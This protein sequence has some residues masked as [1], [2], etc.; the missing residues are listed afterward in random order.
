MRVAAGVVVPAEGI[1]NAAS[2]MTAFVG[3]AAMVGAASWPA[4]VPSGVVGSN[5]LSR[6]WP[7]VPTDVVSP[8]EMQP[9]SRQARHHQGLF[10]GLRALIQTLGVGECHDGCTQHFSWLPSVFAIRHDGV[11]VSADKLR[12]GKQ[13]NRIRST[14]HDI[15]TRIAADVAKA[16]A[17]LRP[18]H[19]KRKAVG[20]F[21]T[22][23]DL[24]SEKQLRREL[25]KLLPEA[26]F[27]GEESEATGLHNDWLWVVDPIDGTSNFSRGL[28]HFAVS[29]ALL[30][31]RQPVLAAIHCAP[32]SAIY[33]AVHGMGCWRNRRRLKAPRARFDDGAIIGCQWFRGQNDMRFLPRLQSKGARIRTLGS[34]VVQLADVVRGR[35]DGNVQQQGRL[36]DFAAAG[37]VAVEAGLRFTDWRGKA[38][39]PIKDLLVEHTATI[40]ATPAVHRQIVALLKR[41][42]P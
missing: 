11:M 15:V 24:R 10:A 25:T 13:A 34:T 26:G 9:A 14:L 3:A 20:D 39:F 30:Y 4:W 38:V 32:E 35:L 6:R 18:A 17:R 2:G 12:V 37:L 29:V 28:P 23:I 19:I 8:C 27:L 7:K 33:T 40:A 22:A 36:W 21:V 5:T 41:F 16:Q 42:S 31:R 1:T